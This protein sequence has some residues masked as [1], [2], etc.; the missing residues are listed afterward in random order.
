[1]AILTRHHRSLDFLSRRLFTP[2]R[3]F[4]TF[5]GTVIAQRLQRLGQLVIIRGD[6]P[7]IAKRSQI[8][9]G[10]E[11]KTVPSPQLPARLHHLRRHVPESTIFEHQQNSSLANGHQLRHGESWP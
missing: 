9:A 5:V 10:I 1:M 7:S 2:D 11:A 3:G 6:S 4:H 8:F